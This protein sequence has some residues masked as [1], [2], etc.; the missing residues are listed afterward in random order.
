MNVI[1]DLN[2]MMSLILAINQPTW[3]PQII[4]VYSLELVVNHDVPSWTAQGS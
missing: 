2:Q 4:Q 1:H 3:A